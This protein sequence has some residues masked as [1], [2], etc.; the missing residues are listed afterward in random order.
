MYVFRVSWRHPQ[1]PVP[2]KNF[3]KVIKSDFIS[4]KCVYS[5]Q[6]IHCLYGKWHFK[7]GAL[8]L[9]IQN[10]YTREVCV[11]YTLTCQSIFKSYT[12]NRNTRDLSTERHIQKK[13]KLNEWMNEKHWT[14]NGA[15]FKQQQMFHKFDKKLF[16]A[17]F[18]LLYGTSKLLLLLL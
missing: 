5:V 15:F 10:P 11:V 17:S 9:M 6:C 8:Y 3:Q 4:N 7:F 13:I 16:A 18:L 12:N 2:P 1:P 14:E